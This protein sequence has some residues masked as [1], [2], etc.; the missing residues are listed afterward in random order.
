MSMLPT[1]IK[2]MFLITT[3]KKSRHRFPH[4]YPY[5]ANVEIRV[6]IKSAPKPNEVF[7]LSQMMLSIKFDRHLLVSEMFKFKHVNVRTDPR[8]HGRMA[9]GRWI[10]TKLYLAQVCLNIEA[11]SFQGQTHA[12]ILWRHTSLFFK[13]KMVFMQLV[14]CRK[15][16]IRQAKTNRLF[17]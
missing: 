2:I 12:N 14:L 1:R 6:M 10:N 11:S 5:R 15:S 8:T 13:K 16:T 9:G 3:E 17:L 4:Y 7:P